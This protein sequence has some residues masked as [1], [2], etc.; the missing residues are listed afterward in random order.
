MEG[1]TRASQTGF[2]L[3]TQWCLWNKPPRLLEL[4][5]KSLRYLKLP[6]H[7]GGKTAHI[8]NGKMPGG[9][10]CCRDSLEFKYLDIVRSFVDDYTITT[11]RVCQG[12]STMRIL[13][14][15]KRIIHNPKQI[16]PH[17][18][19]IIPAYT[20]FG[21]CTLICARVIAS[22]KVFQLNIRA[23]P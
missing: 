18:E 23:Q 5:A 17:I 13:H 8:K 10:N 21:L 2:Q 4:S 3:I 20:G 6:V 11:I 9:H 14:N 1:L 12:Q 15:T 22:Q 16:L 7:K 19:R